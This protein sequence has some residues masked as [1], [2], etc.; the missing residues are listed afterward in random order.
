MKIGDLVIY[1]RDGDIGIVT[2]VDD[3]GHGYVQWGDGCHGW[4]LLTKLEVL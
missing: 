4:H 3:P 2:K 1:E